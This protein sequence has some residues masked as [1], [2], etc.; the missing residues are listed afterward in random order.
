MAGADPAD[1]VTS[2]LTKARALRE[3][4]L[5]AMERE[6]VVCLIY[7]EQKRLVVPIGEGQTDRNGILAAMTGLPSLALPAGFSAPSAT[8][9]LGVPVGMEFLGRP[10]S[11]AALLSLAASY[12]TLA[13]PRVSPRSTP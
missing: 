11:E 10:W 12:E 1:P 3:S 5:G 2:R 13:H 7:P 4:V 8:A 9:P 6:R